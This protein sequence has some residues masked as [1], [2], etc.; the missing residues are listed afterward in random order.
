MVLVYTFYTAA[1]KYMSAPRV[2]GV[3]LKFTLGYHP[4]SL[5]LPG[6]SPLLTHSGILLSTSDREYSKAVRA[7][8]DG[9]VRRSSD[10]GPRPR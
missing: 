7:G 8:L 9:P 2:Y 5:S 10:R 3:W 6:F 4:P 1:N